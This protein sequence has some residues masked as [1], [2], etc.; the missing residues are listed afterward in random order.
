MS[1]IDQD[2]NKRMSSAFSP[3]IDFNKIVNQEV[4]GKSSDRKK[5]TLKSYLTNKKSG[6][7]VS[8]LKHKTT[9][10]SHRKS[11]LNDKENLSVAPTLLRTAR[12]HN[13]NTLAS[14]A[15]TSYL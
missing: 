5:T 11:R 10:K 4:T 6:K 7:R 12:K 2:D 13:K 15:E 3:V 8:D 14:I 1:S 9:A